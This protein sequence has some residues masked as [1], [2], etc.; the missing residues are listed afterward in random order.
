[1]LWLIVRPPGATQVD[2]VDSPSTASS[3]VGSTT[4]TT[5]V[6]TTTPSTSPTT[7]VTAPPSSLPD[8]TAA[9][10]PTGVAPPVVTSGS[11][12]P[13]S[14]GPPATSPPPPSAGPSTY[15]G[16]GGQVTVRVDAGSLVLVDVQATSG[17]AVTEQ[18]TSSSEIEVAFEDSAG[19]RTRVKIRLQDGQ[20]S[21]EVQ[22]DGSGSS[23]GGSGSG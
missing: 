11:T 22:E 14:A 4:P 17:Y 6:G 16:V 19:H 18:K 20:V 21:A 7:S 3:L 13:T 15:G 10:V 12:T 1:M 5:Q 23:G 2:T 9:T 8:T